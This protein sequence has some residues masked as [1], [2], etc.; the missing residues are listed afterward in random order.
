LRRTAVTPRQEQPVSITKT[1]FMSEE[2]YREFALGDPQGQWELSRG[3]LREKPEM[4]VE[5]GGIMDSL[6]AFLY[7]QLDRNEYRI[8]TTH[9]R[10]RRSADTYYVP[11]IAV[12]PTPVVQALL[13]QPGSLDAYPE[14]LPLVVEIW[15]P[16]T[17][18]YDINEKL[19]DYQARGDLEIWYVHPYERTLTARRRRLDGSY[20]ESVYRGGIVRPESLTGVEIDL[21]APFAL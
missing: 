8:R 7:G 20:T 4:S 9:A 16:S 2:T 3:Q 10:L 21:D 12:I 18:R 11:D 5:H 15:S 13:E 14:P 6:L 1:E 17:G 19:P